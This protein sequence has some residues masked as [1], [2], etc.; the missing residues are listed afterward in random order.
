MDRVRV[1]VIGTGGISQLH[2][3]AYAANPDVDIVALCDINEDRVRQCGMKY[4]VHN[5][6]TDYNEILRMDG[7]DAVSVCTWNSV[8]APAAIAALKAGKHV[9]CEKPMAMNARE[10]AEMERTA[11]ECGRLLMIG[12][13]RRFG[14][15]A[16][17][18][19]DFIEGGMMGDIYYA[20][21]SYLRRSGC[22]G[23]WFGDSS[24]SGGGPLIDLGVHV[25]D[26]VRYFMGRPHAVSVSG[27][28]FNKLGDRSGL[29]SVKG[30]VAADQS[31][32]FDVEDMASA[33]VR[34]DNG[35]AMTV[36]T[37]FSLNI[38][39]DTGT[40]EL[41][42][43]KSGAKLSP[44]LEFFTDMNGYLVDVTPSGDTSLSFQGLFQKEIDHY[45]DCLLRGNECRSP[46]GDGVELMK[47]IDGIYESARIGREVVL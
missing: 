27:V 39:Q 34:F 19:G 6:F 31:D 33:L 42:G 21:A 13:V 5:V 40:L 43:T 26:F 8:H 44:G 30:Y 4:S 29:K 23:G 10:A 37:S 22:P 2:L 16:A 18:L 28:A 7:L 24:R 15:D 38:R 36:E 47:I 14:N 11:K 35:A 45:V 25:I 12:F 20:K 1:G 41:F 17:V 32:I 3:D 46:A 9:L